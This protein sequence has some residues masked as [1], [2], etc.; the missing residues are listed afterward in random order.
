MM[1]GPK[2]RRWPAVVAV[3]L[4]LLALLAYGAWYKLFRQV[5][6]VFATDEQHFKYASIGVEAS[7]GLPYWIWMSL[8]RIC[9][10]MLP[11]PGGYASLGTAW[12]PGEAMPIGF[13]VKTVGF[14]RVGIN[15]ATCHTASYRKR[16]EDLP[17]YVLGAPSG[18]FDAQRYIRFLFACAE[19]PRFNA[20][21]IMKQINSVTRLSWIDRTLYRYAIIPMT[22]RTLLKQRETYRWMDSRP[23]WSVGRT[24]MNPFKLRVL[25]LHDDATVGNTD[26]MPLWNMNARNGMLLHSDGL[27]KSVEEAGISAALAAGA[28]RDSVDVPAVLRVVKWVRQ[29]SPPRFPFPVDA[30]LAATG[31][32][33]FKA[34]CADCHS[35]GGARTGT[36]IDK[37]E[38]GTDPNRTDHWPQAAADAFNDYA[39]DKPWDFNGFA[40]SDGYVA[41]PLD[42]V[43]IRAPYL[44]NGSVPTLADLLEPQEK[45]PKVFYR[46]YDVYDPVRGGFVSSG[47][48]AE[49]VGV[50][51][52]TAVRG[53]SNAGHNWGTA[54]SP[55]EKAALVEYMKTL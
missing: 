46:G 18:R 15:C 25:K 37:S 55:E 6:T 2:K 43:W 51:Y 52:D 53:N 14:E 20:D 21:N 23:N 44:H 16:P 39:K 29:T 38:V 19:D 5:P 45:R 48:E 10:E 50:R 26:I 32:P 33:I 54:L 28:S 9:P 36:A 41:L 31:G 1:S 30:S 8:P 35:F 7:E 47:P 3:V 12:E 11:G 13:P 24:D 49:R 34:H 42:G 22:K 40:S 27:S 17:T 4:L